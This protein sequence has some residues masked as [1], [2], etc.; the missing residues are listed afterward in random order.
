MPSDFLAL[1]D[2]STEYT[3][4]LNYANPQDVVRSLPVEKDGKEKDSECASVNESI[5]F[6]SDF[7]NDV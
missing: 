2:Q 3:I 5:L 4:G 6:D 1:A 7:E